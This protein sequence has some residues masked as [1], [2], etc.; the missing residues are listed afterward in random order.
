[1]V[2]YFIP[3]EGVKTKILEFDELTG[4]TAF[5]ITKY[6][7]NILNKWRIEKKVIAFSGDSTNTNFGGIARRVKNNVYL[8]LK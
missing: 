8:K 3:P 1:M 5:K 7:T 4:E 2:R 6:I